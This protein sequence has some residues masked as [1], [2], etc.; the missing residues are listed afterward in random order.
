MSST[1]SDLAHS[2][3]EIWGVARISGPIVVVEGMRSV[4]YDE[5][6]QIIDADGAVRHGRVLE[7]SE[8]I[9]VIEVF[10]GTTGLSIDDT[11]VQF[12]GHP[13]RMPVAVEMLGRTKMKSL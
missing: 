11:R 5:V 3:Q 7:V 10:A 9:A 8:D 12:L 6:V 13:M 2:G 4:A 1:N